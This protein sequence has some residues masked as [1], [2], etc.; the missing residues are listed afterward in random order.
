MQKNCYLCRVTR[1]VRAETLLWHFRITV[2]I[3]VAM[4]I[5]CFTFLLF[6]SSAAAAST[7]V[8]VLEIG[9]RGLIQKSTTSASEATVEGVQAFWTSLH[10][11]GNSH[12]RSLVS[13]EIPVA[14]DL[15]RK[16]D[17]GIV[18][19]VIGNGVD[20]SDMPVLNEAVGVI[21]VPG[22]QGRA[23]VSTVDHISTTWNEAVAAARTS[24]SLQAVALHAKDVSSV[25]A[26]LSRQ[27]A[28][29][30]EEAA[31]HGTSVV[32]H[33]IVE[34]E[35]E[36]P[37]HR[38]LVERNLNDGENAD[39]GSSNTISSYYS[40]GFYGYGYTDA[41]GN[42]VVV[43]KTI[44]QIQYFQVVLWTAIGL[45]IALAFCFMLMVDMPL[46]A[47]TLLFGESSKMMGE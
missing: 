29:L 3:T 21:Q 27:V 30:R 34:D 10:G 8:A 17:A 15:F 45:A 22:S 9:S 43:S 31:S 36:D 1:G 33:V 42:F 32:L 35:R 25:N 11:K 14:G 13:P 2:D 19:H 20:M 4:M 47:D 46:M 44:F 26:A 38:Q 7:K 37:S 6:A 41:D 28:A 18:V 5:R 39:D 40:T 12:H 24:N 23:L 16:P